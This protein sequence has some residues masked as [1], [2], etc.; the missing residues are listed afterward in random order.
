MVETSSNRLH[1]I[2]LLMVYRCYDE[3]HLYYKNY[4]AKGV[5]ICKAWGNR[6]TFVLWALNNG[7]RQGLTIDRKN[8]SGHY[9]S[10]NCRWVSKSQNSARA[11]KILS[12]DQEY[13]GV[14]FLDQEN[15]QG[16]FFRITHRYQTITKGPYITAHNAAQARDNYIINKGWHNTFSL[17]PTTRKTIRRPD[18]ELTQKQQRQLKACYKYNITRKDVAASLGISQ[19]TVGKYYALFADS[20]IPVI[21]PKQALSKE[22][23]A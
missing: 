19:P 8:S 21:T 2:W 17:A 5:R 20:N 4:G 15:N 3:D 14:F 6:H 12:T 9:T 16:Y 10:T 1:S 13:L 18:L 11:V 23:I 7:Y 22:A